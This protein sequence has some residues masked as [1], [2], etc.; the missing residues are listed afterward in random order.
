[1]SMP[2]FRPSPT[3]PRHLLPVELL[4][5]P[6]QRY[7]WG[8][9]TA[10]PALLGKSPDGS[11]QAELWLG[12]HPLASSRTRSGSTLEALIAREPLRLLG[13]ASLA[14]FGPRLPF[15][16]KILAAAQ[17]L[18]LQAHPSREQAEAG[19]RREEASGLP[20]TAPNR[21]Y[22][23][24]NHKPEILCALTPFQA[25]SGFRKIA[26]SVRLLRALSLGRDAFHLETQGLR[27]F[28]QRVMSLPR[29]QQAALS[30]QWVKAARQLVDGFVPECQLALRLGALYPG[31]V[32]IVGALLL[33]LVTLSPGQALYLGAG[34]LHAYLE[35]TGVELMANSDNVL[36]GGLTPKHVDVAE[37]L[38]VLNF[39][40][41]PPQVLQPS[42]PHTVYPT[43]APDFCLSRLELDDDQP[44]TLLPSGPQLLLVVEGEV[45]VSGVSLSRGGSLFVGADEAALRLQGRGTLFRATAGI[46][47]S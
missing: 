45:E 17:P 25:L 12:A 13:E 36:R 44:I 31:D 33:N 29:D 11:P 32:G 10:I 14:R 24:P 22:R 41:G 16:L 34:N 9:L 15:L 23:D 4:D 37:L 28:F 3:H 27:S 47:G 21:S 39:D 40:D 18:S 30:D 2:Y 19:F 8:S 7:A 46:F 42:G 26:D 38:S 35:G 20:L 5:N 6:I 43:P 1:M